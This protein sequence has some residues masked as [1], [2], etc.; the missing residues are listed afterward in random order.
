MPSG[1]FS[2]K[3]SSRALMRSLKLRKIENRELRP[4]EQQVMTD[5]LYAHLY[6]RHQVAA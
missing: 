3:A 6:G 1:A 2:M 5:A 4:G